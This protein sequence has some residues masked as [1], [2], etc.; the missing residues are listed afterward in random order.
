MS[1]FTHLLSILRKIL[2]LGILVLGVAGAAEAQVYSFNA[3]LSGG[4]G[5]GQDPQKQRL[6]Q[7]AGAFICLGVS[8]GQEANSVRFTIWSKIQQPRA[9]INTVAFD[10]GR[11]AGLFSS[12]AVTMASPRVK[13]NVVSPQV[14]PFLRG[15]TPEFWVDVPQKGHMKTDGLSS[16]RMTA[17]SATLGAGKT[18]TGVLSALSEGLNLATGANGLRVGVIGLYLLGGP[19]PGA[20]TI[21]DDG[22]FVTTAFTPAC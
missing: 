4:G 14:H 19:A 7:Q 1:A 10:V 18:I 6:A 11:H 22:G 17:I 15:M 5:G 2:G 9:R 16:G 8:P 3:F 13:G 21:Q 12:I 20:A